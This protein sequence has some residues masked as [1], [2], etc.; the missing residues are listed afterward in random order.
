MAV[1]VLFVAG[2]TNAAI[3]TYTNRSNRETAVFNQYRE[4]KFDDATPDPLISSFTPSTPGQG[5]TGGVWH[6]VVNDDYCPSTFTFTMPMNAFG[7]NW[8]PNEI[9]QGTGIP[10]VI[11]DKSMPAGNI[12]NIFAG[13]F[14]GFYSDTTFTSVILT[15]WNQTAGSYGY[16]TAL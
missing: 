15:E 16:I 14:R 8:K 7:D 12:P 6:D 11:D 5:A 4:E 3:N 10:V 2:S 9:G 1:V 13:G